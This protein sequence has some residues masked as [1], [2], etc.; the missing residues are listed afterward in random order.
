MTGLEYRETHG[1]P[2]KWTDAEYEQYGQ[3][4][5][6][7]SKPVPAEV[8]DFLRTPPATRIERRD[9]GSAVLH[10]PTTPTGPADAA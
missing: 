8:L 5:A 2:S 10:I 6:P 7:A 9:D 3:I 4:A 1:D